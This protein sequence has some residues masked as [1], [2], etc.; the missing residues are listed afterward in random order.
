MGASSRSAR[1][2]AAPAAR[3]VTARRTRDDVGMTE[4]PQPAP[5]GPKRLDLD[6]DLDL[7]PD[8]TSDDTDDGWGTESRAEK[9]PGQ[10]LRRYLDETPPH[11]GD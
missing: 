11:H 7:V 3:L 6:V 4:Q 1:L 8:Q 2:G 9:D 10:V 5:P